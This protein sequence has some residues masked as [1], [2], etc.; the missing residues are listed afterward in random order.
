MLWKSGLCCLSLFPVID[1]SP[2][3][4]ICGSYWACDYEAFQTTGTILIDSVLN[5]AA[6]CCC[7]REA[8]TVESAGF[9]GR[10]PKSITLFLCCMDGYLEVEGGVLR[11]ARQVCLVWPLYYMRSV[12]VRVW[13]PVR[14]ECMLTV[15]LAVITI[16]STLS[17][18]DITLKSNSISL[19]LKLPSAQ[20]DI[21]CEGCDL[22]FYVFCLWCTWMVSGSSQFMQPGSAWSQ[23]GLTSDVTLIWFGMRQWSHVMIVIILSA[24]V[25]LQTQVNLLYIYISYT[26]LL[27]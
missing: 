14:G 13:E 21:F 2:G 20:T 17:W 11:L 9:N 19:S 5:I 8:L 1:L 22:F 15:V 7:S 23:P 24:S 16:G 27:H 10:L 4:S 25:Y 26:G 3:L 6:G 18:I 12:C